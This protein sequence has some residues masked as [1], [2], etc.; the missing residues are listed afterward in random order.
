MG[1]ILTTEMLRESFGHL[2]RIN[3]K[4]YRDMQP[5]FRIQTYQK[6]EI[7]RERDVE[8]SYVHYVH[9][10]TMAQLY[11][12]KRGRDYRVRIFTEGSVAADL[13]AY[14]EKG[15]SPFYLRAISY[16]SCFS[17][18]NDAEAALL[19]E[20]PEIS[21]LSTFVNRQLLEE[22]HKYLRCFQ[23]PLRQGFAFFWENY[24][25]ERKF[26]SRKD[27]AFLFNTS[28]ASI[29]KLMDNLP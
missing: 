14:F 8:E 11:P 21:R 29:K 13:Y 23:L 19:H 12:A 17:L 20:M 16:V 18:K 5:Y 3:P 25:E 10:G 27:L 6:G 28:S 9:T 26:L 1:R 22:T 15:P 4:V 2:A 24:R 7:I